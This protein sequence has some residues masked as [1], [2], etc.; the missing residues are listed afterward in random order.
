M[1]LKNAAS[2]LLGFIFLTALAVITVVACDGDATAS[3][4]IEYIAVCELAEAISR[5]KH[6]LKVIRLR[7][8]T[9]AQKRIIVIKKSA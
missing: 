4:F 2:M 7:K 6:N 8:E 3:V 9:E 5:I 1:K